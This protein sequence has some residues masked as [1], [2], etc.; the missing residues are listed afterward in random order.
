MYPPIKC[1]SCGK[2]L[3]KSSIY[4]EFITLLDSPEIKKMD[5]E[6]RDE[7]MMK[8]F[9][10]KELRRYCCRMR[11]IASIDLTEKIL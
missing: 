6:K 10:E 7:R 2:I 8:F 11:L 1:Y 9:E 4:G 3:N 5:M